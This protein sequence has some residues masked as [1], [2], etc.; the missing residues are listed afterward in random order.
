MKERNVKLTKSVNRKVGDV[1]Y[2][3]H[4]VTIPNKYLKELGWSDKTN[5]NMK[6][7]GKKLVI[8]KE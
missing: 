6:V 8:E 7:S 2:Y 4:I 5:L 3:K 1:E